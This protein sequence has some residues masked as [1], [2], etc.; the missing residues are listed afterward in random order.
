[1]KFYVLRIGEEGG[2]CGRGGVGG[3]EEVAIDD[4]A[5]FHQVYACVNF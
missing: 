4:F 2:V 5:I 1:M 3:A